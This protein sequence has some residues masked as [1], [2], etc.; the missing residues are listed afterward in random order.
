MIAVHQPYER[1]AES[2]NT[3]RSGVSIREVQPGCGGDAVAVVTRS[4]SRILENRV[5]LV[6]ERAGLAEC[7]RRQ[8]YPTEQVP[9]HP[10]LAHVSLV[11]FSTVLTRYVWHIRG[12][13]SSYLRLRAC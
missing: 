10:S 5:E 8:T 1:I 4:T 2:P 13:I 9:Y 7:C 11:G 6:G 3:I 12:F